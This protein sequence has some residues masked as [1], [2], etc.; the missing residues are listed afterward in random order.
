MMRS[1]RLTV[2]LVTKDTAGNYTTER[3]PKP[4]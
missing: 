3:L 1:G 2:L 4:P